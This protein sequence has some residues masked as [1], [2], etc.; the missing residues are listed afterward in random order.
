MVVFLIN[1]LLKNYEAPVSLQT[2]Y[3]PHTSIMDDNEGILARLKKEKEEERLVKSIDDL[4]VGTVVYVEMDKNDGL[5]ISIPLIS[6]APE[7]SGSEIIPLARA[8]PVTV[9]L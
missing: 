1:L 5:V 3:E 9:P 7:S 6:N 4:K 8:A 2:T